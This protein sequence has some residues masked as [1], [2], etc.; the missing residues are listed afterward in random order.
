MQG[1][2]TGKNLLVPNLSKVLSPIADSQ[3]HADKDTINSRG[4]LDHAWNRSAM[5]F[6]IVDANQNGMRRSIPD[7][8][9]R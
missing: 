7:H 3:V 1:S 2:D 4:Y 6:M 9:W 5:F 8:G